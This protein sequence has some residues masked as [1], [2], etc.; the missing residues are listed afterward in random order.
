MLH[1]THGPGV[2]SLRQF[3]NSPGGQ[4]SS[5]RIVRWRIALEPRNHCRAGGQRLPTA[6]EA[7]I[8][9][10][11]G[12]VGKVVTNFGVSLFDSTINLAVEDNARA[13]AG[14]YRDINQAGLI[15]AGAPPCFPQ[16]GRVTVVLHGDGDVEDTFQIFDRILAL[17][18]GKEID[19]AEL[20]RKW[21]YGSGGTDA[22]A[23]NFRTSASRCITQHF[24]HPIKGVGVAF[25]RR[26]RRLKT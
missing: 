20:T 5:V 13:N 7:T 2:A 17:P 11:A 16:S 9:K 22:N 14:S 8:A 19:V 21:I 10:R 15:P 23:V 1:G 6:V 24:H 26:R 25:V 3:A 12:G 18:L 4:S